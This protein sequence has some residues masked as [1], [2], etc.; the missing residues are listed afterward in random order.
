MALAVHATTADLKQSMDL[1]IHLQKEFFLF[2]RSC[3]LLLVDSRKPT[4][5]INRTNFYDTLIVLWWNICPL[6]FLKCWNVR[7]AN[8]ITPNDLNFNDFQQAVSI[9]LHHKKNDKPRHTIY[10]WIIT[11]TPPSP[12]REAFDTFHVIDTKTRGNKM[13]VASSEHSLSHPFSGRP[14]FAL[15]DWTTPM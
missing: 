9:Y 5:K 14:L 10:K 15:D 3:A 6:E 1:I 4:T 8:N 7:G 2:L 12:G 13:K 11:A